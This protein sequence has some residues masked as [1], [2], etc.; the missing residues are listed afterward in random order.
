MYCPHCGQQQVSEAL[1]FCSKCGFPLEGVIQLL[2]NGGMLPLY[3]PLEQA[4]GRS[5]RRKGVRQG[6]I[7]LL[8]GTVVLPIL[9]VL[10]GFTSG[11]SVLDILV[12]LA[13]IIF[14]VG[15]LVRMLFAA[16]FEEGAATH[17][18]VTTTYAPPIQDQLGPPARGSALPPLAANPATGWR[19]RPTSAE[20]FQP[21]SVTE[22]TTRLLDKD[23]PKERN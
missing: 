16:L 20:S 22:N 8:A 11:P 14:F 4:K 7:L 3:Q 2:A 23:E 17:V 19:P 18:Q 21:H 12:P 6:G 10:N 5:P 1:R 15:G 13:A 9:G